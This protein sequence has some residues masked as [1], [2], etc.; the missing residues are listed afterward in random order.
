MKKEKRST[1]WSPAPDP[2][3][4][5]PHRVDVWRVRVGLDDEVRSLLEATLSEDERE[6]A[7]RFHFPVDRERFIASHGC[8][9]DVLGRYLQCQPQEL[10]F[11]KGEHGKPCLVPEQGIEFNLAHSGDFAL[12]A[13]GRGR[14]V[15]VDVERVRAGISS[16]VIARQYFSKA[17]VADLESLPLEQRE[18]AFFTCW[19]RKEAYIKAQGRGLS[20]PLESFD[21]SLLP[22][23]P[24]VLRATRP[25]PQEAQRWT[26][27]SLEADPG[28][29]AALAVEAAPE[30]DELEYRLWDWSRR[31]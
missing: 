28:Y 30:Q 23:Q 1:H 3:D 13:V 18:T 12:I 8:L 27:L 15:G 5:A 2:L 26:L 29:G 21:V 22:G 19:T 11:S 4:L 16:N 31:G 25:D 7:G 14:R 9:R 6:R 17:E 24:A 10:A 20:L